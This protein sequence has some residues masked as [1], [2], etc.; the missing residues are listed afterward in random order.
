MVSEG[1][2]RHLGLTNFDTRRM[3]TIADKS[4]NIVSNQ[5]QYSMVDTRPAQRMQALAVDRGIALLCYGT[6]LGGL[7]SDKWLGRPVP[8][9]FETVSQ[10]KYLQMIDAWGGWPLF[11]QLL[12]ACRK[13][14][15]K[16][17][18][19][20]S[21]NARCSTVVSPSVKAHG[22]AVMLLCLRTLTRG[23]VLSCAIK[24]M[25]IVYALLCSRLPCVLLPS[26]ARPPGRLCACQCC[27]VRDNAQIA[28]VGVRWVIQ[29]PAVGGAIVGARLGYTDHTADSAKVFTFALDEEDAA[30][31]AAVQAKGRNLMNV[32]GDCGDEYRA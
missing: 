3:A 11:Q 28:N 25:L 18:V 30:S 27:Y 5:V 6:L 9:A 22:S 24:R 17:G 4:I 15:D 32:I 8:T 20:V 31:I 21:V 23:R 14:A 7:L 29:Q 1:S 12:A 16:H 13:V 19:S 10:R 2:I 26:T